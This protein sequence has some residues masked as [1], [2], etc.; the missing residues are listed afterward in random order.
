M[1]GEG[2]LVT[3][4][5]G[6]LPECV[7]G[8]DGGEIGGGQ[9]FEGQGSIVPHIVGE[10]GPVGGV[11]T[12]DRDGDGGGEHPGGMPEAAGNEEDFAGIE[13]AT[14]GGG[15]GEQREFVEIG[16]LEIGNQGGVVLTGVDVQIGSLVFGI[17]GVFLNA[18]NLGEESVGMEIIEVEEG[19][20]GAA[21]TDVKFGRAVM[22]AGT[23]GAGED[24]VEP[25]GEEVAGKR[26]D[27]RE[28]LGQK[29]IDNLVAEIGR[30]AIGRGR[31]DAIDEVGHGVVA[32]IDV[33]VEVPEMTPEEVGSPGAHRAPIL[34]GAGNDDGL[35]GEEILASKIV[36]GKAVPAIDLQRFHWDWVSGLKDMG[37][38]PAGQVL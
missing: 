19:E 1:L 4:E 38:G 23:Q 21:A 20:F 15:L 3:R 7:D 27:I 33:E 2:L 6:Q 12:I 17:G 8:A 24:A 31:F 29:L 11:G 37:I 22:E 34:D 14:H 18:V 30:G 10:G 16:I 35:S 36:I 26:I 5:I 9:G 32:A 28:E 13:E 25:I